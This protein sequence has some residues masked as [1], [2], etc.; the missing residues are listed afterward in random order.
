MALGVETEL[1]RTITRSQR[2]SIRRTTVPCYLETTQ[3]VM[4]LDD[5]I[6]MMMDMMSR[7]RSD[8]LQL[9]EDPSVYSRQTQEDSRDQTPELADNLTRMR[10]YHKLTLNDGREFVCPDNHITYIPSRA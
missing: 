10:T 7:W 2:Q 5:M 8:W 3:S 6:D 9:K 4:W 1:L